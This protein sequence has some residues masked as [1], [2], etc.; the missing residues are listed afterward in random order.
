MPVL[1]TNGENKECCGGKCGLLGRHCCTSHVGRKLI[2]TLFGI[3]LVYTIVLL[4]TMIRNNLQKYYYI[5]KADRA[6]RMITVEAQGKVTVKPDLGVT[7]MGMVAEAKTVSEAQKKNTEVMNKLISRLKELGVEEKDIQTAN[8]NVYPQYDYTSNGSV[9]KGYQVSQNVTIKIRDL[10]KADSIL[11]L[12]G[13]VGANTVSGLQ[14][15]FDDDEA[16]KAQAREQALAKIADKAKTLSQTLGVR[17]ASV[18]AYNE[19]YGDNGYYPKFAEAAYGLGGG[20]SAPDIQAGT[21]DVVM[22]VNVV[23]EI[24]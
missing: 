13:E 21:N 12:A 15:T 7:T 16:Y 8:Y 2:A 10:A 1:K 9:L 11:G 5:G 23:F 20:G 6:E 14:F 17:F 19:Y 22:N 4:G 24:K 3:L 18:V